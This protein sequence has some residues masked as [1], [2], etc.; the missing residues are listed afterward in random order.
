MSIKFFETIRDIE[1]EVT[2]DDF[3]GDH[4]IGMNYSPDTLSAKRLDDGTD[5]ELTDDEIETLSIKA[6]ERYYEGDMW[7]TDDYW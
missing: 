3:E 7:I 5:F 1:V 6:S 4:A 2:A